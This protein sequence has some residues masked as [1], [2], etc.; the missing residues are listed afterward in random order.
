MSFVAAPRNNLMGALCAVGGATCFSL[1]DMLVKFLSGGY[2]LHQIVLIRAGIA[3]TLV[4]GALFVFGTGLAALRTRRPGMHLLRVCCLLVANTSFFAALAA[5]PLAEATALFFVAPLAIAVLSFAVLGERVGPWRWAAVLIGLA[6]V[7]VSLRPGVEAV[8]PAA[9]L[10]LL[11]ALGYAALGLV[12]RR[13]GGTE[14]AATMTFYT[15]AGLV[16][17]SL[18]VGLAVGDGRFAGVEDA[19]LAFLLRGW[20]WPAAA[21]LW[22]FAVI[23]AASATGAFLIAQAYRVAEA[24]LVAPFEYVALPM[25]VV[26]GLVVFAEVPDGWAVVGMVLIGGGGLL[27]VWREARA[28]RAARAASVS[29]RGV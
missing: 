7:A 2:A 22:V 12:T 27:L 13:I 14:G 1:N 21:D 9:L 28:A 3:V 18:A 15:Q 5:M 16:A 23:G 20:I 10:A 19:S 4:L 17:V 8:Q 25:A 6:G 29:G 11:A 26:W 24:G